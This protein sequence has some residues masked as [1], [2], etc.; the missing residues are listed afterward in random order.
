M[1]AEASLRNGSASGTDLG[2]VNQ[3]R[4]RAYG[5]VQKYM[6]TMADFTLTNL[7]NERGRE[8]AW[9][10]F[11]RQDCIRFGTFA[12]ARKPQKSQ[13]AD[14]HWELYPIPLNQHTSNPNLVQNPGYPA[15]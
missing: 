14:N 2:Y 9:E 8:L 15:F 11:R 13:D 6:W 1:R 7:F 3:I 12:N 10:N 5:G 4:M